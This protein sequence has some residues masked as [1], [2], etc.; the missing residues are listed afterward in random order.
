MLVTDTIASMRQARGWIQKKYAHASGPALGLVPTMG[1]LHAGHLSL[2][3]RAR[4]ECAAVAVSIF[5]N[6]LQFGAGEDFSRYPRPFARDLALLR[7]AGVDLIFAPPVAE[8]YPAGASTYV[9]VGELGGRL[10]GHFRPGHFRGVTTVVAKLFHLVQPEI[11]YFGQKDAAQLA[12]LRRMVRDLDFN[13][14]LTA[15]PIVRDADGL[16]LSSRNAYL[17][18]AERSAALALPRALGAM[19]EAIAAGTHAAEALLAVG[20]A[21]L[22]AEPGVQVEY[23]AAVDAAT[24]EPVDEV[25]RGTLVA[26]A[27]KVGRTRLIDNFVAENFPL[28]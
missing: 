25:T 23:L 2:I 11:A 26:V 13:L 1:A 27:A 4:Q 8:M 20:R 12:V 15:C 17:T 18:T 10:D 14:K 6:P 21:L 28:E 7:E 19:Q 9:E 3:A 16:A 24:L 22:D 5:V